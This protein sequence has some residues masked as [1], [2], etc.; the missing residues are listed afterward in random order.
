[1]RMCVHVG[2]RPCSGHFALN[3]LEPLII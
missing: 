2:R 3:I 1:V